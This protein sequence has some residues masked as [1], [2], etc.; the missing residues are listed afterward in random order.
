MEMLWEAGC[1]IL[2]DPHGGHG[3]ANVLL[4]IQ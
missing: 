1:P 3:P 2:A 4:S